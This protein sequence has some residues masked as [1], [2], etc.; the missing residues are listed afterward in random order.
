MPYTTYDFYQSEYGGQE[1]TEQEFNSL[2]KHAERKIDMLTYDRII[3][4]GFDKFSPYI[5]RKI[6]LAV[7]NQ[8]EYFK[9]I[10]GTSEVAVS[11]PDSVSIGRTS[12]SDSNFASTALS[13]NNGLVGSD[14]RMY[15][16]PTGLLYAGVGVR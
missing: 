3:K 12:I 16:A 14:V 13:L 4:K 9:E 1:L 15:L 2:V 8:I 7:C 11:T 5:Q 6:Q 10:G